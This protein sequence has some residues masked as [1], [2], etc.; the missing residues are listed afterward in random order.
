MIFI[1]SPFALRGSKLGAEVRPQPT[2]STRSLVTEI[3]KTAGQR[4][5][6]LRTAGDLF[7]ATYVVATQESIY[8]TADGKLQVIAMGHADLEQP[9]F[10]SAVIRRWRDGQGALV[11]AE[12]VTAG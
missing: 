11:P 6:A 9:V 5:E 4:I 8:C 12:W 3:R 7:A 1:D 10:A 2:R